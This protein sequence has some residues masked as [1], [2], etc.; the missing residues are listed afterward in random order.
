MVSIEDIRKKYELVDLF[1]SLAEIPSP[2][3]KEEKVIEFICDYCK[4][5][6]MN[7]RLD[8][9]KNVYINIEPTDKNKD[10]LML[11]AHMD[12]IGDD[13]PVNLYLEGN[14]IHAKG[15]TLG[16]DDKAGVSN[17]L[18]FAKEL[19]KSAKAFSYFPFERYKSPLYP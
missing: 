18:L 1:C 2:S 16:G 10:S 14:N 7:V 4:K 12:V 19:S 6:G 9:Y 5:N 3:K 11:S 15:R 8:D 13:S 17:A